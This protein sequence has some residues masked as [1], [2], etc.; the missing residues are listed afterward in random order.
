M[1][2]LI[3]MPSVLVLETITH[4]IEALLGTS[5]P[6]TGLSNNNANGSAEESRDSLENIC[7]LNE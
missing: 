4:L 5:F 2:I 6:T 3:I 7:M 1:T